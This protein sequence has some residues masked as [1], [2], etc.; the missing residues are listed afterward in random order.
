MIVC[1]R[2][3]LRELERQMKEARRELPG[4]VA[5]GIDAEIEALEAQGD[6]WYGTAVMEK[7][8]R[9]GPRGVAKRTDKSHVMFQGHLPKW[10]GLLYGNWFAASSVNKDTSKYRTWVNPDDAI[11][12]LQVAHRLQRYSKRTARYGQFRLDKWRL[13]NGNGNEAILA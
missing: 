7:V 12:A 5:A 13:K 2:A 10:N 9:L 3:Y 1:D 4:E 6:P 11:K 8:F